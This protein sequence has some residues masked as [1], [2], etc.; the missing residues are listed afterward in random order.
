MPLCMKLHAKLA[1]EQICV[2]QTI[3]RW[4]EALQQ[5]NQGARDTFGVCIAPV[6]KYST[7]KLVGMHDVTELDGVVAHIPLFPSDVNNLSSFANDMLYSLQLKGS[8]TNAAR[9]RGSGTGG[10]RN[11]TASTLDCVLS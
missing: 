4:A 3:V 7:F 10:V 11:E 1:S 6:E 5:Q 9:G 8:H 2:W